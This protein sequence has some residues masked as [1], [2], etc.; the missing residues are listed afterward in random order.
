[1]RQVRRAFEAFDDPDRD[2]VQFIESLVFH[3]CEQ[4]LVPWPR[5]IEPYAYHGV[6]PKINARLVRHSRTLILHGWVWS[7]SRYSDFSQIA[8]S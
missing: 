5:D 1:M 6:E 8:T 3:R 4:F 7:P 2:L